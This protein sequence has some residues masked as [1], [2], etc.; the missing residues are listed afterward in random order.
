MPG[1]PEVGGDGMVRAAEQA[2][3]AGGEQRGLEARAVE[4]LSL[5]HI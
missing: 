4:A 3:A 1:I 5:I 2:E